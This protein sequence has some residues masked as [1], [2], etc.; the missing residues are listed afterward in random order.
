MAKTA[1]KTK[2]ARAPKATKTANAAPARRGRPPKAAK[3]PDTIT[4]VIHDRSGAHVV[5]TSAA[6]ATLSYPRNRETAELRKVAVVGGSLKAVS[7]AIKA[8]PPKEATLAKGIDSRNAP[9]SVKAHA[10]NK[11]AARGAKAEAPAKA[12]KADKATAKAE[13]KAA[14]AAKAAPKS[15]DSRKITIVDKKFTFGG[16][17]TTRRASWDAVKSG[18]TVADYVKAGGKAKYLPRWVS[19]GAIKLG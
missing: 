7:A 16:E 17:G 3:N 1:T 4:T 10:D 19:A 9:H 18:S 5:I 11:R 15:D 8:M 13:R 14:R 6:D 2:A 12:P